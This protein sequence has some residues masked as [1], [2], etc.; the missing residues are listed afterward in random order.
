MVITL[1]IIGFSSLALALGLLVIAKAPAG[2][3]DE[4]GFHY[5]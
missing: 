3:Q 2:Y 5:E 4:T 1:C